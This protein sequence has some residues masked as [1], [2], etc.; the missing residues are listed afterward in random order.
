[1]NEAF[2]DNGVHTQAKLHQENL[3]RVVSLIRVHI[4]HIGFENRAFTV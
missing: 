4:R 3:L 1:M 2:R